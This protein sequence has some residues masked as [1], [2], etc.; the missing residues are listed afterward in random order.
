MIINKNKPANWQGTHILICS[1]CFGKKEQI[2]AMY[3]NVIRET[4]NGKLLVDVFGKRLRQITGVNR[5]YV[6]SYRVREY[7]NYF[8][9]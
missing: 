9:N 4:K 8:R 6:E 1:H 5:R 7:K 2:Y 3:C